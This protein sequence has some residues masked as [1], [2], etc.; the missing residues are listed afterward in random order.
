VQTGGKNGAAFMSA[1]GCP[2]RVIL[3]GTN[4]TDRSCTR[5]RQAEIFGTILSK[6]YKNPVQKAVLYRLFI[7]FAAVYCNNTIINSDK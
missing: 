6:I 3:H 2:A 5:F 4:R 7:I 1:G